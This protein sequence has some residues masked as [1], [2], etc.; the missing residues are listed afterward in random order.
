MSELANPISPREPVIE[1]TE[2]GKR[3]NQYW[4]LSRDPEYLRE[5]LT[6]I[7]ENHWKDI[8]W[9]PLIPG[10]AYELKCPCAPTR[11]S[12][13]SGY[14]TVMFGGP[15]FH[16]C[17]GHYDKATPE[18]NAHRQPSLARIHRRLDQRGAPLSW[19]F[20]MRNGKG[21]PMISIFFPNPFLTDADGLADEP[22]WSKLAVWRDI[23]K[24][25]LGRE[26][27]AFDESG[28]GYRADGV[29]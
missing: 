26:P 23:A 24:R 29:G 14:L 13:S 6:Y 21:E 4:E 18:Q 11:I 8:I 12:Y 3:I 9:G 19:G 1:P 2:D 25:Y 15:H 27:E 5:F 28:L 7:F 22:N 16:L 17:I 10:A 20:E